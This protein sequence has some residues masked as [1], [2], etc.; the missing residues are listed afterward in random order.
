MLSLLST[1]VVASASS[2][3]VQAGQQEEKSTQLLGA[4]GDNKV[5]VD[6]VGAVKLNEYITPFLIQGVLGFSFMAFFLFCGFYTTEA[7]VVP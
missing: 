7:V 2:N 3:K 6:P 5:K 4:D 1:L